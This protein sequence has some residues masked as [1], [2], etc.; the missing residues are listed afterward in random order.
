MKTTAIFNRVTEKV[1]TLDLRLSWTQDILQRVAAIYILVNVEVPFQYVKKSTLVWYEI[2]KILSLGYLMKVPSTKLQNHFGLHSFGN[3]N[4]NS[5][6][7]A[8]EGFSPEENK[9]HGGRKLE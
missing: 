6:G 2:V 9:R 7:H 4:Q 5:L 1:K 3:L 8:L